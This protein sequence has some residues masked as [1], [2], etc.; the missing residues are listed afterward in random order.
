MIT[1]FGVC[2]AWP[3]QE[4]ELGRRME[5]LIAPTA[6]E[7]GCLRYDLYRS[8]SDPSVWVFSEAWRSEADLDAHV[9][10][11][12][13]QSFIETAKEV[14]ADVSSYHTRLVRRSEEFK[15]DAS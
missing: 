5:S 14:L 7:D 10:S 12:H 2:K 4:D 1:S 6:H 15:G 8:V 3:G 11:A 13:F 9:A